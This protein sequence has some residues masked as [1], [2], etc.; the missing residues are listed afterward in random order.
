MKKGRFITFEGIDG[1][2]KSTQMDALEKVL[3]AHGIEVVRTGNP[4]ARLWVK[5]IR[6]MLLHA[7]MTVKTETLLFF[8]STCGTCRDQNPSGS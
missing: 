1:A 2:G 6:E 3:T 4:V 5:K 8:C 7:E